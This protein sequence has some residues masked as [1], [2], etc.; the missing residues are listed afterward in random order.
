M[1]QNTKL[2][3]RPPAPRAPLPAVAELLASV[4]GQF[5]HGPS[6][7]TLRQSLTGVRREPPHKNCATLAAS[8]AGSKEHQVQHLLTARVWEETARNRHRS[9]QLPT[10]A[11]AGEGGRSFAATGLEKKGRPSVGGAHP[12]TGSAGPG[13]KCQGTGTG[14]ALVTT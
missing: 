14:H 12:S 8:L 13:S 4:R 7:E 9:A 11:S 5:P 1:S 10:R 2:E 6:A 3:R